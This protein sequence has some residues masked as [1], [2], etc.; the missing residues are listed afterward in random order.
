MFRMCTPHSVPHVHPLT[1]S[2]SVHD[3]PHM[4]MHGKERKYKPGWVATKAG[5]KLLLEVNSKYE[6]VPEADK[7]KAGLTYLVRE[8]A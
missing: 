2:S 1:P 4:Q 7:V 8:C 3:V 5:S 6:G